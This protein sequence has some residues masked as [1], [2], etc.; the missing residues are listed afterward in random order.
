MRPLASQ[1]FSTLVAQASEAS[2]QNRLADAAALYKKALALRPAW[3][4]GWW[5]LGTLQYDQNR[6]AQAALAFRRVI[7][8]TSKPGTA[9][10]M[11]GLCEFEMGSDNLALRHIKQGESLGI[12]TDPELR[13]VAL[14]HQGVLLQRSG[15]FRAAQETLEQLCLAGTQTG[16]LNQILGM[17]ALRIRSRE[18][19]ALESPDADVAGRVGQ[20]GCLAAQKRLDEA[21]QEYA[22]A[23][24]SFPHY[25]NIHYAYGR[26]LLDA[27]DTAGAVEQFKLEIQNHPGDIFARLEIAAASYKTNSAAGL[28]YAQEAV[29]LNSR[30]PF[31]HYLL[32]LLWLDTD[33]FQKA[34]P[35]LEIARKAFPKEAKL[36]F[37]LSSAYSRA[38]RRQDA[39]RARAQ[40]LRLNRENAVGSPPGDQKSTAPAGAQLGLN[41]DAAP[42]N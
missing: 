10:V 27:S 4:E 22:E 18:V 9:L 39:V 19:P 14:Y 1:D 32:G 34:I 15:R 23:A 38:G 41:L 13:R 24:E 29:K 37:A 16:E 42:P 8:L 30:L 26:F 2:Q 28:A 3:A 31:A 6:Y 5:S 21:R 33:D 11:L 25:P 36:Y 12:S 7:A 17:A 40:F 35:E 20:A